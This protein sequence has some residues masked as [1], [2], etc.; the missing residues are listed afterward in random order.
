[1]LSPEEAMRKLRELLTRTNPES[2][3]GRLLRET[4][5][6]IDSEIE[7]AE[8]VKLKTGEKNGSSN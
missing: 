7:L 4:L 5:P 8:A 1:M 2:P 6:I 3:A